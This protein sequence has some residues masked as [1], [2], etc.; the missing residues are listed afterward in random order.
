MRGRRPEGPC[1]VDGCERTVYALTWCTMH[2]VRWKRHGDPTTKLTKRGEAPEARFASS[3]EVAES[4]CWQW[5]GALRGSGYGGFPDGR[6]TYRAH[7]WAYEHFVGP[8]PEGLELDHLCRNKLC[9]NPAHLEPVTRL[10]NIQ[11]RVPFL[12]MP[13]KTHCKHG[14]AF[15]EEN[16]YISCR[17]GKQ[18]RSCRA[19]LA[20]RQREYR[21]NGDTKAASRARRQRRLKAKGV[22]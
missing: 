14:H 16:T 7:R 18:H 20:A 17:N 1:S 6:K 10:V 4:G 12:N 5:T 19:C 15:T 2:Y 3:Y 13:K 22:T 21:R 9:V 8:I 11:R